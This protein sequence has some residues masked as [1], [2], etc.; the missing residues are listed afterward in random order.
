MEH[1]L[2]P[3][4]PD[5]AVQPIRLADTA[6]PMIHCTSEGTK[7]AVGSAPVR[8]VEDVQFFDP[9]SDALKNGTASVLMPIGARYLYYQAAQNWIFALD[10]DDIR[11]PR[12]R[13]STAGLG[14]PQVAGGVVDNEGHVW[15]TIENQIV[16]LD[17]DLSNPVYSEPMTPAKLGYNAVNIMPDG[18]LLA[19][20]K[21][22]AHIVSS[23][24]KAGALPL[25][26]STNLQ[27]IFQLPLPTPQQPLIPRPVDDG[28]GNLYF[29]AGQTVCRLRYDARRQRLL[30]KPVW[31]FTTPL[32]VGI[33]AYADP[34]LINGRVWAITGSTGDT[35]SPMLLSCLDAETGAVRGQS[36]PFPTVLDSTTWHTLGG[37]PQ[38]GLVIAICN[39]G[40]DDGGGVVAIDQ[41]TLDVVWRFPLKNIGEA[42]C[43]SEATGRVYISSMESDDG[44]PLRFW[45]I[46]LKTGQGTLLHERPSEE[47]P[48]NSLPSIGYDGNLYYPTPSGLVKL[49]NV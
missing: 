37:A 30:P 23:R 39:T 16:R 41:E 27:R 10:P 26:S 35:T 31:S 43:L 6:W 15:W 49:Q 1:V 28:K 47:V 36:M 14:F 9:G 11:R 34:V 7:E 24:P 44:A 40:N 20:C 13:F 42:F 3:P 29:C 18:N 48:P 4:K 33:Y 2:T 19:V 46:S 5:E 38:M 22:A 45:A 21:L 25:L 17:E 8:L 12:F 32:E